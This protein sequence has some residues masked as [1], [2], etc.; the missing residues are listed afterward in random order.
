MIALID[1]GNS[2]V[3]LG[4]LNTAN[5]ARE[6]APVA[7]Q[8]EDLAPQIQRWFAGLPA[9]PVRALGVNVAA[10][11]RTRQ[12]EAAFAA[13]NCPVTWHKA[14]ANAIGLV[15]RYA[16]PAQLGAD[17]WAAMLGLL[18][19]P[20][21]P[22]D[23]GPLM[24]ASFG[25]ATTIDTLTPDRQFVGG[26]ILP[27]PAMML[28]ALASGTAALPLL[29]ANAAIDT[30]AYPRTTQQAIASGT[31]AAQAGAVLR[32]WLISLQR[33]GAP[34]DLTVTGGG[35]PLVAGEVRRVLVD[36]ARCHNVPAPVIREHGHLVLDGLAALAVQALSTQPPRA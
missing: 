2:R 35:W 21:L 31:A 23:H 11:A 33:Y 34:P 27:G 17:R 15:N 20:D 22:A 8:G 9:R 28:D 13:H 16:D 12:I 36:A 18:V 10:A 29:D 25:T 4:W 6:T 7:L 24:L 32:Q 5:G 19:Q 3:K 26:L 30:V 1:I 14:S